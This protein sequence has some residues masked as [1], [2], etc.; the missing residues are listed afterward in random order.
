MTGLTPYL[1]F[2]GTARQ[3]LTFYQAVFGGELVLNTLADFNRDRRTGRRRC[4]RH[5]AGRGR[6]FRV[7]R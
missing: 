1:S 5:V 4:P 7:G 2:P 6:T 3:A